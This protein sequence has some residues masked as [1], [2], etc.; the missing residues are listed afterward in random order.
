MTRLALWDAF[1][2]RHYCRMW[3]TNTS[4]SFFRDSSIALL[5][6]FDIQ[7]ILE[8]IK[9]WIGL[10]GCA[11]PRKTRAFVTRTAKLVQEMS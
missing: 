5:S 1:V 2:C 9:L 6:R 8:S 11:L 3:D 4:D 7:S 10:D